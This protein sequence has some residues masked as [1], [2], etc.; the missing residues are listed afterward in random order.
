MKMTMVSPGLKGLIPYM[1][2]QFSTLSAGVI[3]G[4][5]RLNEWIMSDVIHNQTC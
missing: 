2:L 4:N 3:V 1:F 5:T